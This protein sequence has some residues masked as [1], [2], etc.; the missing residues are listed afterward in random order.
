M[1]AEVQQDAWRVRECS[2]DQPTDARH[3]V[4]SNS[5]APGLRPPRSFC[6]NTLQY[7]PGSFLGSEVFFFFPPSYCLKD[8]ALQRT[9]ILISTPNVG[10]HKSAPSR[11]GLNQGLFARVIQGSVQW[12]G[13][14]LGLRIWIP[15]LVKGACFG[16]F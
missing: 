6:R 1:C 8:M 11:Y 3:G 15:V 16:R 4:A 2:G 14:G 9:C 10:G 7:C 13:L 5:G 12:V